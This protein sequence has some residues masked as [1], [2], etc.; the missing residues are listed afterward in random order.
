MPVIIAQRAGTCTA[1]GCGGRISKGE[2][3]SYSRESGARHKECASAPAV[4]LNDKAG[5]CAT[6]GSW[7]E[8][9]GG[10]LHHREEPGQEGFRQRYVLTCAGCSAPA[11]FTEG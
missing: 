2:Y 4:R 11:G 3:V 6:C 8:Q 9:G 10:R 1:V 5:P 7:V